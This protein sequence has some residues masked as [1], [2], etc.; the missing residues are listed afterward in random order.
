MGVR[1][2]AMNTVGSTCHD[3]VNTRRPVGNERGHDT[4][5]YSAISPGKNWTQSSV[6]AAQR[7]SEKRG[8]GGGGVHVQKTKWGTNC[9]WSHI[10]RSLRHLPA[11]WR[12]CSIAPKMTSKL[13]EPGRLILRCWHGGHTLEEKTNSN[14]VMWHLNENFP[15]KANFRLYH[16]AND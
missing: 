12:I 14:E 1:C 3:D 6:P 16:L 11:C 5:P 9:H 2:E 15:L 13:N 7:S 4:A 10:K 8:G